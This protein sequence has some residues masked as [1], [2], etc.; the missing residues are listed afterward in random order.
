LPHVSAIDTFTPPPTLSSHPSPTAT[1]LNAFSVSKMMVVEVEVE[2]EVKFALPREFDENGMEED[3][4]DVAEKGVEGS[5]VRDSELLPN[6]ISGRG[7]F[8]D[9]SALRWC[10]QDALT[11]GR[12]DTTHASI[13][14]PFSMG[15]LV[16]RMVQCPILRVE[17]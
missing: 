11:E 16:A 8:N 17:I 9:F 10:S 4:G 15:L 1:S 5:Y 13:S 12:K 14:L 3:D 2:A 7:R 6:V